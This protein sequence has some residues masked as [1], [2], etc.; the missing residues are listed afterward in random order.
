V[1]TVAV[2]NR[3]LDATTVYVAF[4]SDSAV[5]APT[6]ASFCQ[7]GGSNLECSFPL[8]KGATRDL[9]LGGQ[10]LNATIS[11]GAQVTCGQTKAEINV[12]NP[13]WFDIL[14]VSLVDGYSNEIAIDVRDLV[15][16]AGLVVL[17]PPNGPTGNERVYGLFPLGCDACASRIHPPCGFDSGGSG[18]KG[19][20]QFKPE[21]APCQWQ[22]STKGGGSAVV[23]RLLPG[24]PA[25]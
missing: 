19:G 10:Y 17:G 22:G 5:Q 18:C 4:G 21:P 7:A 20:T 9:P 24:I 15:G 12:N 11:F 14:D 8:A 3:S 13:R 23:V 6:W 1:S 2:V 25:Q 16:D